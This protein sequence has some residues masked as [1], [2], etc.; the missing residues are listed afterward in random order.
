MKQPPPLPPRK[1]TSA[2]DDSWIVRRLRKKGLNEKPGKFTGINFEG[3]MEGRHWKFHCSRRSRTRYQGEIRQRVYYGHRIEIEVS[4]T[5]STRLTFARLQSAF[6]RLV[7][8]TN[9]WFGAQPAPATEVLASGGYQIWTAEPEWTSRI[10]SDPAI[11]GAIVTLLMPAEIPPNIGLKWWPGRITFSQRLNIRTVTESDFESWFAALKILA[12]EAEKTQ[13]SKTIPL[14]AWE[15]WAIRSP[16]MA[17]C[18]MAALI[19]VLVI[20]FSFVVVGLLVLLAVLVS[21]R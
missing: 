6:E 20:G 19:F 4:T 9:R 12:E 13:P 2:H 14:N 15:K 1:S 21:S 10:L 3:E 5:V 8:R 16:L 7:A 18:S 17:G 11:H